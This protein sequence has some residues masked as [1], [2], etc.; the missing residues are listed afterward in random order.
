MRCESHLPK[1][2]ILRNISEDSLKTAVTV[3][4]TKDESITVTKKR[5]SE[6]N[7]YKVGNGTMNKNKIQAID[8]LDEIMNSTKAEQMLI[9]AIKNGIGY[10]ND[11][12]YVVKV[13]GNT[14]YEQNQIAVAYKSLKERNLVIRTKKNHYMINPNALIPLD[15]GQAVEDW[16]K[17]GGK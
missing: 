7:Y 13:T 9:K 11:Y 5:R 3:L 15:Y 16:F 8:L 6:P 4:I 17:A 14:K 12:Y 10:D 2:V 1:G